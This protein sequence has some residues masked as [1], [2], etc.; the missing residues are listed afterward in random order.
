LLTIGLPATAA[1]APS[2]PGAPAAPNAP[3]E[4]TV[5]WYGDANTP[6]WHDAGNWSTGTLPGPTDVVCIEDGFYVLHSTGTTFV[7]ELRVNGDLTISGGSIAPATSSTVY[8]LHLAGGTLAPV[9]DLVVT[10]A[11]DWNSGLLA[12]TG[13]TV[14]AATAAATMTGTGTKTLSGTLVNRGTLTW[15]S[16]LFQMSSGSD[17]HLDNYGT[18]EINGAVTSPS[19]GEDLPLFTNRPGATIVKRGP[20]AAKLGDQRATLVNDGTVQVDGGTLWIDTHVDG[21]GGGDLNTGA[22]EVADGATLKLFKANDLSTNS[23]DI[24]LLGPSA[25]FQDGSGNDALTKLATN[26]GSLT[27]VGGRDLAVAGEFTNNGTLHLGPGSEL[28]VVE[29]FYAANGRLEIGIGG[30][31]S[32]GQVVAGGTA[33]LGGTVDAQVVAPFVPAP[34][35]QYEIISATTLTGSVAAI[36]GGLFVLY[37]RLGGRVLLTPTEP[38]PGC[39]A[40]FDGGGGTELWGD[41][42]NWSS[43]TLPG[44]AEVACISE[45]WSVNFLSG[46]A[47]VGAIRAE[48]ALQVSGGSLEVQGDST[49][50]HLH[51]GGGTLTGSG[52]VTVTSELVWYGGTLAGTGTLTLAPGATGDLQGSL[53]LSRHLRNEGTMNYSGASGSIG[54]RTDMDGT[55]HLDNAGSFGIYSDVDTPH[56]SGETSPTITNRPGATILMDGSTAQEAV[57]GG[58]DV[59]FVNDGTVTVSSGTLTANAGVGSGSGGW[60][61]P[62]GTLKFESGDWELTGDVSGAGTVQIATEGIRMAG[63]GRWGPVGTTVIDE[64]DLDIDSTPAEPSTTGALIVDGTL[65]GDGDLRVTG[66]LTMPTGD[67]R[68]S[69]ALV[70]DPSATAVI[71]ASSMVRLGRHLR[72]EGTL[73]WSAGTIT[74]WTGAGFHAHLDNAGTL[75]LTGTVATSWIW[76][77]TPPQFTNRPGATIV[78]S[79]PS[80]TTATFGAGDFSNEGTVRVEDGGTLAIDATVAQISGT[81]LTGGTWEVV[82]GTLS[83]DDLTYL[84]TNQAELELWGSSSS[85]TNGSDFDALI[86][87]LVTNEGVLSLHRRGLDVSPGFANSGTI[88]LD[89]WSSINAPDGFSQSSTGRLV[90]GISGVAPDGSHGAIETNL[91]SLDGVLE[92][93]LVPPDGQ[94]EPYQPSAS[95][96][97]KVIRADALVGTFSSVEGPLEATY[98]P[99]DGDV[100]LSLGGSPTSC[101]VEWDGSAGDGRWDTAANWS[102]D[103][104]PGPADWVCIPEG[105]TANHATGTSA[106]AAVTAPGTL[107]ISGG[108][109]GIAGNSSITHLQITGGTLDGTGGIDVQDQFTWSGGNL[110]GAGDLTLVGNATATVSGT[111][112]LARHLVNQGTLVWQSGTFYLNQTNGVT[113]HLDNHATFEIRDAVTVFAPCCTSHPTITNRSGATITKTAAGI[114]TLGS[115]GSELIN[116]GTVRAMAGTLRVGGGTAS[117]GSGTWVADSVLSLHSGAF[118]LTGPVTGAGQFSSSGAAVRFTGSNQ[119]APA[120]LAVT[121]GSLDLDNDLDGGNTVGTLSVTAGTLDGDADLT[122]TDTLTWSGSSLIGTGTLWV[123]PN[124]TATVSGTVSLARHLVN[125]G[126]LVWQSGTFYLN[127]TNGVTAHLDNHA[128]FEIRDAVTVFAP[129]CTSHPTITNRSGA[130]ITKTAA[131]ITTLGSGGS[132]LINDGTVRAMAGT[133]RVGGGTASGGSGTWVADSVL[134]LHSGAFALTGPVTG[135]GQFSSS[136]AAVRFTGSNQVAPAQLAVTGGSLD[137]DNDLDGG[138]TVGTLSVTS[139]TLDGDADLTVTDTLT[140]SGSSLIGTGTLWVAPN[141]TGSIANTATLARHL[142]N[143]GTLVW[144]SGVIHLTDASG[145]TSHLDN[146]GTFEVRNGETAY[147]L[148]GSSTPRITNRPGGRVTK[149]TG[150]MSSLGYNAEFVNDGTIEIGSSS[151][152]RVGGTFTQGA[153]GRLDLSLAGTTP[154]ATHGQLVVPGAAALD[155]TIATTAGGG[156]EPSDGDEFLVL[157]AASLSGTFATADSP[158]T[159]H[160]DTAA[161]T[162]TLVDEGFVPVPP[163]VSLSPQSA[164]ESSGTFMIEVHGV[165]GNVADVMP[166]QVLDGTA[167]ATTDYSTAFTPTTVAVVPDGVTYVPVTLEADTLD[168]DDETFTVVV[169]TA[170]ATMTIVDDDDAP[171]VVIDGLSITEGDEGSVDAE[172]SVRLVDPTFGSLPQPSSRVVTVEASTQDGTAVAGSDYTGTT[173]TLVFQ[174]GET[175][176][177][178]TVPILGDAADEDNEQFSATLQGATNA[179]IPDGELA[180][181]TIVDDDSSAVGGVAQQLEDGGGQLF[182]LLDD[183]GSEYDLDRNGPSPFELPGLTNE[184]ASL[185]EPQDDLDALDSPF[186]GLDEDFE[187]LCGQLEA[188]GLAIDWVEGGVCGHPAPPTAADIIQV[189]YTARLSELAEALGFTGDEFNDDAEGVLDGLAADLG[190]DADF[191]SSADLV[192]TLVVGVDETGF[193]VADESGLR[194]EVGATATVSGTGDVG[195]V[196]GLDLEGPATV[197][198]AVELVANR[199]PARLRAAELAGSPAAYLRPA[200][201]GTVGLHLDAALDPVALRWDSTFTLTIDADFTTDIAVDARLEGVLTLPGLTDGGQAATIEMV[202]TFDGT[203]W[204]LTGEGASAAEYALAGFEVDELGFEVVLSP[205]TFTGTGAASLHADLG[206]GAH[207]IDIALTAGFDHTAW[208]AEGQLSLGDVTL[209]TD[210]ALAWLMDVSLDAAFDGDIAAGTLGGGVSVAAG[211]VVLNPEP[212]VGG[213]D[214]EGAARAEDVSGTLGADG[215]LL[216]HAGALSAR[217]GDAIDIAATDVDIAL[218]SGATDPVLTIASVT[219]TVPSLNGL[220]VTFTGL[221]L[222]RDGTW[223]A[224]GWEIA[225]QGLLQTI[226]LGGIVPFDITSVAL[227]FPDPDDL[228]AFEVSVTGS[229]DFAAMGSLPFTPLIGLGG[230]AISPTSPSEDNVVTFSIAV[231]SLSEARI[232]PWDLG[233]ITLG[234]DDLDVGGVT[235]GSQ[236]TLGAYENG[237]WTGDACGSL[238][239]LA[240]LEDLEGET[241]IDVCGSLDINPDSASLDL[242]GTFSLSATLGDAVTIEGAELAFDLGI[243]VDDQFGFAVT[244]PTFEGLGVDRIAIAFGDLMRLVGTEVDLDFSP[245]PGEPLVAFGG[246]LGDGSLAVEFDD[247][248]V[249]SGWGGEAGN[250]GIAADGTVLLLPG[251]FVDITVPD[252]THFGLPDWLPL[253]VDEVGIRFPDV[254]LDNIPP[255]GLPIDDLADF[256]IRFSG[257]LE[258]T[259]A[260]PIAATVDGLEVDLG[261]LSR[262]EFP[263]TNLDGF[264][265][266]VEPFELVPGFRVGGGLELGTIDVDGDVASGE[267]TEEVLYGRIFGEF[268]YEGMGAGID[269]VVSQYGPVLAQLEVPLAIPLDGGA[270]GGVMLSSV[271]GGINFGGPAFPD[272]ERPLDILHDPAFDTD[273]PVNDDTIRASVEPA[274]QNGNLTWDN[275]FTLALSGNLTHALAPGIVTGD[276]TLGANI[277]LVPGQQGLKFIGSGDISVWGMSYAG[278]ALLMDLTDPVNPSF[279]FAFETPQVGNPLS[280]LMPAQAVLEAS[281]DTTGILSGFGLGVGTFVDRLSTGSLEVGQG[282]FDTTIDAL[283]ADLEADHS[284]YL[285]QVVLD[286]DRDGFVSADE[287]ASVITRN[288]LMATLSALLGT[289]TGLPGDPPGAGRIGQIFLA[290]LLRTANSVLYDAGSFDL[291]DVF[292]KADYVAF[293]EILGAGNEAV[294]AVLGV[295]RDSVIDAGDAFM[296][297][298]DPSFHLRGALQPIILGIPF[299]QPQHEVEL[300]I[301]KDGLGFGFDTS[302]VDIGMQL[303]DRIVPFISGALCRLMSLGIEDHLGMTVELPLGGIVEGLFGG[304]GLPTIDPMSGDW[305]IELRGGLRW[306]DFEVGQMTGLAIAPGNQAFLDAHVQKLYEDPNAPRDVSRI[307]IQSQDHYDDLLTYGGVLLNGRLLLPELLTDPVG[308]LGSLDLQVP[309]DPLQIPAW[310]SSVAEHLSRVAQPATVQLYLPSFASVLLPNYDAPTEAERLTPVGSGQELADRFNQV[311]EAAYLEGTFDGTLLSIPFGKARVYTGVG[312]LGVEGQLP[313]IGLR[314]DFQLDTNPTLGTNGTVELPR[315]IAN[316]T[317]DEADLDAVLA[318]L[319]LP[320]VVG[321][322]AGIDA[323]FRAVSPAYDPAS[324][325]PLLRSGG[326]ELASHLDIAGL[327]DDADYRLAITPSATGGSPDVIGTSHVGRVGLVGAELRNVDVT[328]AQQAGRLSFG[329]DG[330]A[331]ILGATAHVHGELNP[332]LTGTLQVDF[333]SGGPRLAGFDV[334]TGWA[335]TFTRVDGELVSTFTYDGMV[336]LPAWLSTATG[337]GS[338]HATG[339]VSSEGTIELNLDIDSLNLFGFQL[340]EGTYSVVGDATSARMDFDARVSFLGAELHSTGSLALGRR[341]PSGSLALSFL[342]GNSLAFGPVAVEGSLALSISPSSASISATGSVDV[343]GVANDLGITGTIASNGTG[344][345]ALTGASLGIKGFSLTRNAGSPPP[346]LASITRTLS[347]TTMTVDA[348]FNFLGFVL[349][350]DGNL[351]L[352]LSGPSGSLALTYGGSTNIPFGGWTL[353]GGVSMAISP[354]AGS[355]AVSSTIDIP[356]IASNLTTTGSLDSTLRGSMTVSAG[357]L[358]LGPPGSPFSLS[359]SF[360]LSRLGSPAVIALTASGVSLDWAGVSAFTVGTFSIGT[361]GHFDAQVTGKTVAVSQFSW[362]LPNFNLHVGANASG[363]QLQLGSS[364]LAIADIGTLTIPGVNIDTTDNF[365]MTLAATRLNMA[366]LQLHG[367]LIFERQ[368][369]VFRLRVTGPNFYTPAK[370]SIP[371]LATLN[372]EDFTISSNG[373]FSVASTAT[374]LGPDALSIRNAAIRVR[375]TGPGIDTLEVRVAGGDL[376]LPVGDPIDLPTLYIDGDAEWSHTFTATGIDLGPALRTNNNPSFTISLSGSVLALDLDETLYVSVLADSINMRLRELHVDSAGGFDGN[377]R[378]RLRALGYLFAAA[379]FDVGLSNGRVRMRIPSSDRVTVDLGPVDGSFYGSIYSDGDFHFAGS[380]AIDLTYASVGLKGTA[381]VDLRDNGLSGSYTGQACVA[382]CIDVVGGSISRTGRLTV[383]IAGI[384]Y[385]VQ[386]FDPPE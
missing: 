327:V 249:F 113:A 241:A 193:Y 79:G 203:T 80:A 218:G 345:L 98:Y 107:R 223:G 236:L 311:S 262:G 323:T 133:L 278:T 381:S 63:Q 26:S 117:G 103:T 235:L 176:Q 375:K 319:G 172:L 24:S 183:W 45:G 15:S 372:V 313:L 208:H 101:N 234:F 97:F 309:D 328:L 228:D 240:G 76:G 326:I 330:T 59:G 54:L 57:L 369:G 94:Q 261:K 81:T 169:G 36:E 142:V 195:G 116:D 199:G 329:L 13:S 256:A 108:T 185:Y 83:L 67:L 167:L 283:V 184:L 353:E 207:P 339:T 263:I 55:A 226:G 148:T 252:A 270:L 245:A 40:T 282:F 38:P 244:G 290:D 279:D 191:D 42:A 145:G 156:F 211:V 373:T 28:S 124:A 174:P 296:S 298:F 96:E 171:Q 320:P 363:I 284:R 196:D 60:L 342:S 269:L 165:G 10:H 20:G 77:T 153:T 321:G 217:I 122:V 17:P 295:M 201:E 346:P 143:Q 233:P 123:A 102:T 52:D 144:Q 229:I 188:R 361:D 37:D 336:G 56:W 39:D 146:Y 348:R 53:L 68:G 23:A 126:T 197:D 72:N 268:D 73:T 130:T 181:V 382:V 128:T 70:I 64:G 376:Y 384:R 86:G 198:V 277:G 349:D 212:A 27:L 34:D 254:D 255:E 154:G 175:T 213:D 251:F 104:L 303:C 356:G 78:K 385:R 308:L 338:V 151:T 12:G 141:A 305:A 216:L 32:Y 85:I 380:A 18:F 259:A 352:S 340:H 368:S 8:D 286:T 344:S 307:P 100:F 248:D 210:P 177:T 289:A 325:D 379:T 370:F 158:L 322:V 220:G 365:S 149:F 200:A 266:G 294:A 118:A 232:R 168:E 65:D 58:Y 300:I 179:T 215:R 89:P 205:T 267:Q 134:S 374:R 222:N 272:P 231:E 194:L 69:G 334:R 299:G 139:G 354:T 31:G 99:V 367:K 16:G 209:G 138:N 351:S 4:C 93:V 260:W 129:C 333:D 275:G 46:T 48:G 33:W 257:G 377:V 25:A 357:S 206:D 173:D 84:T 182:D 378:G 152:L 230:P 355:I 119:V 132:E 159:P 219:A 341:G 92:S 314:A 3:A 265:M 2:A 114:T 293:A 166:V 246:A 136:G 160:Y 180:T 105:S 88:R 30:A 155:G 285:A 87:S 238:S 75:N 121:G 288:H 111:V 109:L 120:Q 291:A 358:L 71:D 281:L 44:P 227:D 383:W 51:L 247:A 6:N 170:T 43:G 50:D 127:Q 22:W 11:L 106:V 163:T 271:E 131:G 312:T 21:F 61:V 7:G 186:S 47:T 95:D 178:F 292:T 274:V 264:K 250:I 41:P 280:F 316:V 187:A 335:L 162:V 343:P 302:V 221:H 317:I 242:D 258:A 386:I 276:V 237:V 82:D 225:S 360:T 350:V 1:A 304:D 137:L 161:G 202:G 66:T 74:A 310:V 243:A 239:I 362:T 135:A 331:R 5:K 164:V 112:S 273:F 366:A 35:D 91:A 147:R 14:L 110:N 324:A 315:A 364:S 62:G 332:D 90:T 253:R 214:P 115:G 189:R 359:G 337:Q 306:L 301:T 9:T 287:D 192:V 318:N 49:I 29:D 224:D 157:D 19:V 371:S 150:G 140:W 204:T 125:Q 190:L 347:A 297:Q